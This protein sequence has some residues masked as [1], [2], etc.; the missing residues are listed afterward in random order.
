M[1][2]FVGYLTKKAEAFTTHQKRVKIL[3]RFN[4]SITLLPNLQTVKITKH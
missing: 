4:R 2:F 1:T 3:G